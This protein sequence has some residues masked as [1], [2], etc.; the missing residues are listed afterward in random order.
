MDPDPDGPVVFGP[1][2]FGS[3]IICAYQ[4]PDLDFC[5]YFFVTSKSLLL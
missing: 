2:R 4:V 1:P 3:V 5:F